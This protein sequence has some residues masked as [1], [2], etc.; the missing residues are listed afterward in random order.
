[1]TSSPITDETYTYL[2]DSWEE[3]VSQ[4]KNFESPLN[5]DLM[6]DL[7]LGINEKPLPKKDGEEIY[8]LASYCE[9]PG[10]WISIQHYLSVK[11]YLNL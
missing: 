4:L 10:N 5:K 9:S 6:E 11:V 8:E 3:F 7:E 1:M 2:S